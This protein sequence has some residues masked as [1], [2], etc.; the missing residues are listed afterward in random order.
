LFII[1]HFNIHSS[2]LHNSNQQISNYFPLFL[3]IKVSTKI[4]FFSLWIFFKV[5]IKT[6]L[7]LILQHSYIIFN[8]ILDQQTQATSPPLTSK[9]GQHNDSSSW[10]FYFFSKTFTSIKNCIS[11]MSGLA[12]YCFY[13]FYWISFICVS[14]SIILYWF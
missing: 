6:L 5:L 3:Q 4:R 13:L 9:F 1:H 2:I 14:I 11:N 8:I 10:N 7:T 12:W